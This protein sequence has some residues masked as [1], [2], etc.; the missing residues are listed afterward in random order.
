MTKMGMHNRITA[1]RYHAIK[2]AMALGESDEKIMRDYQIKHTTLRYIRNS[3]NYYEYRLKTDKCRMR[4]KMPK[5]ILPVCGMELI[6]YPLRR[7]K[8][9]CSDCSESKDE[10]LEVLRWFFLIGGIMLAVIMG[11]ACIAFLM[12]ITNK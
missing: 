3:N 5:V 6:D 10:G 12:I 9:K 8:H 1:E 2:G 4:G 11:L 7:R